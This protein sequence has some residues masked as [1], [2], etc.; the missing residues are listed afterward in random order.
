[1]PELSKEE[2]FLISIGSIT[3]AWSMLEMMLDTFVGTLFHEF[4]GHP[5]EPKL[6][7]TGLAR[8]IKFAKNCFTDNTDL[9]NEKD[10]ACAYLDQIGILGDDRHWCMH[11]AALNLHKQPDALLQTK[12]KVVS[13]VLTYEKRPISPEIISDLLTRIILFSNSFNEFV[14]RLL[15][16]HGFQEQPEPGG[17]QDPHWIRQTQPNPK[18]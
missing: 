6:F 4:G 16:S 3:L 15:K 5:S 14:L 18:P 17:E 1:M 10:E 12:Y 11:G 8:K 7:T 13:D 9:A 2:R